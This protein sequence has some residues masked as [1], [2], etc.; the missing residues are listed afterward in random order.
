MT[1]Q[2]CANNKTPP[3]SGVGAEA[4]RWHHVTVPLKPSIC[5]CVPEQM[6]AVL[7]VTGERNR[8]FRGFGC[9]NQERGK[10]P[11]LHYS[12]PDPDKCEQ[13]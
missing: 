2:I 3:V 9:E 11:G 12:P 4:V 10:L 1:T 6:C 7:A 13:I 5:F 8:D